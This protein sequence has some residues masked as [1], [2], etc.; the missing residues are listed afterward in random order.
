VGI[1]LWLDNH[2]ANFNADELQKKLQLLQV[3][4]CQFLYQF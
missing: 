2:S 4:V 1:E 3:R